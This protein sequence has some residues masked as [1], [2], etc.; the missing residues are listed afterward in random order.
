MVTVLPMT[1]VGGAAAALIA[2]HGWVVTW[3]SIALK[4]S[5]V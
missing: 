1:A 2:V 4:L 3:K 5:Y